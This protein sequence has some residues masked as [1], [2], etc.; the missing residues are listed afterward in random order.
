[1]LLDRRALRRLRLRTVLRILRI[2][3]RIRDGTALSCLW[4]TAIVYKSGKNTLI[5]SRQENKKTEC[6]NIDLSRFTYLQ[7]AC[8]T[9]ALSFANMLRH[10][11]RYPAC[12]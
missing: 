2:D 9:S 12:Y 3:G 11:S 10:Y 7:A 5:I 4:P 6:P 1:M 8:A